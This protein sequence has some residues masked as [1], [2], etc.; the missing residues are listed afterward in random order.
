MDF[1]FAN[2]GRKKTL[3]GPR[4]QALDCCSALCFSVAPFQS[5]AVVIVV[6]MAMTPA[7]ISPAVSFTNFGEWPILAM[8]L[9]QIHAV[10]PVFVVVPAVVIAVLA[11]VI[12]FAVVVVAAV[13]VLTWNV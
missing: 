5:A 3:P 13:L 12:A 11:V 4:G 10:G 8:S 2:P 1:T 6:R 9:T 7:P